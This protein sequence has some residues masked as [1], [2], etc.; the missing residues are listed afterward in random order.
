[1]REAKIESGDTD[2][3]SFSRTVDGRTPIAL[4]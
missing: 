4:S 2:D 1:M 3:M